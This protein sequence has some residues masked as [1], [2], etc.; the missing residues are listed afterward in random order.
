MSHLCQTQ[1]DADSALAREL[2]A[3]GFSNAE[4]VGR[5]GFGVVFRCAQVGLDRV[6][7][8]KVLTT[9]SEEDRQRFVR[10]QRAMG[11]LTGHPNIVGVLQ[12]GQTASGYPYLV[13]RYHHRGSLQERIHRLGRLP[14]HEVL[15][16]GV[17][18]AGA[19]ESAH[20]VQIVH[21]DVKP[22]NILLTDF[23]QPAL[24]DFGIAHIA[25]GFKT[26]TGTFTGSP[27]FTAPEILS[28]DPPSAA[29]DVYGLGATLFAALT[30]H[31]AYER[32]VGEQ[33]VAQFLRITTDPLPDLREGEVSDDVAA[34]I[35]HAMARDPQQRPTAAVLGQQLRGL[36]AAHG[37]H[38]DEV[39]LRLEQSAVPVVS[40]AS[41]RYAGS[42]PAELTSFV[43]RVAELVEVQTFL[44]S[45]RLVTVAGI[46]GVGKTRLALR[47]ATQIERDFPDGVWFVELGEVGDPELVANAVVGALGLRDE[48]GRSLPEVLIDF[49]GPRQAALVID[50]CEHVLEEAGELV[51]ALLRACPG[52]RILATSRERLGI[53]GE[54]VIYLAPLG[55]PEADQDPP[56]DSVAGYDAIALF[57]ERAAAAVPGFTLGSDTTATV[58]R[59]CARVDGLPLAIE[60]AAARLRTMSPEQILARLADRF[61]LLTRGSRQAPTRQQALAYSVDW[62]YGL[63]TPAE[64]KLWARLSV[65]A[66]SFDLDAAEGICNGDLAPEH[67]MDLLTSLVDKSIVSRAQTQTQVRFRLLETLRDYGRTRLI[68]ADER[69]MLRRRHLEWYQR[70]ITAAAA[71]W[72]SSRQLDWM[73]RLQLETPNW[74]EAWDFA[75]TNSP[76]TALA[77][78]PGL[79]YYSNARGDFRE[80]GGRLDHALKATPS[81]P[82]ADRIEALA[83]ATF[84]AYLRGDLPQATVWA[85]ESRSLAEQTD[86]P[87]SH[88]WA[89]VAV[90]TAAL[91][92][93]DWDRA[94]GAVEVALAATDNPMVQVL[95]LMTK[96]MALNICGEL[97]SALACQEKA[98]A[99]AESAGEVMFRSMTLS[100]AGVA[101]LR[102]GDNDRAQQYLRQCL[103]LTHLVDHVAIGATAL[104]ALAWCR[105]ADN[106]PLCA[107]VLMGAADA[108]GN[109]VGAPPAVYPDLQALHDQCQQQARQALGSEVF[110]AAWQRGAAM[111]FDQAVTYALTEALPRED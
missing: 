57:A 8:V 48:P 60:L 76:Q 68:E 24:C 92:G 83:H 88:G 78:A 38:E 49:L 58:A 31:A 98:F 2:E 15:G 42:I 18:M 45:S 6:V 22:A 95:A 7:A 4:V 74:R 32:K 39:P 79:S 91:Y 63:C 102:S 107:T 109:R 25:E 80:M 53:G 1:R 61:R 40:R 19:L 71:D 96:G 84:R 37:L 69:L 56:L 29:S 5:G 11:R 85:Q 12:V 105:G 87:V 77:M 99:I 97:G 100:T 55:L 30:G 9:E 54:V 110:E 62:S 72:F 73:R 59:I 94:L 3:A 46:G 43:G 65:F 106:D 20:Q 26:A 27:S 67:V 13:M 81:E 28:G 66:A 90:A 34:V 36:Q 51:E 64:Q 41:R 111:D 52:L 16:V 35:E 23:G 33:V 47:A 70:M 104:D 82:S 93:G 50:N 21:R 75:L 86:N 44:A 108:I 10:E 89:N 17:K 101:R 103:E 14:L